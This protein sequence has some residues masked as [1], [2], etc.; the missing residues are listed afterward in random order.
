M[1]QTVKDSQTYSNLEQILNALETNP[2]L[3]YIKVG[4]RNTIAQETISKAYKPYKGFYYKCLSND[5]FKICLH[6]EDHAS[7]IWMFNSKRYSL[8]QCLKNILENKDFLLGVVAGY[9]HPE[10]EFFKFHQTLIDNIKK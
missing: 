9:E 6:S 4:L 2:D 5:N 3:E 10:P 7:S 1:V 8:D